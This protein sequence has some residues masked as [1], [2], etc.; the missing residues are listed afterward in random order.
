ME[1]KNSPQIVLYFHAGSENHGCEAIVRSTTDLLCE[2]PIL[3]SDNVS[4]DNAYGIE[5]VTDLRA[6]SKADFNIHEKIRI[7]LSGSDELAYHIRAGHE[8]KG[9]P[10][11]SIAFSIGGDNYCYGDTYNWHLSG[12]NEALHKRGIKTVLWGCSIEP[13][14]VTDKMKTDFSRYDL[15][16]AREHISYDYLKEL[17]PN[18]IFACDPAFTLKEERLPLPENFLEGKTVGINISPLIQK[19]E[20]EE[21][22]TYANYLN[23]INYILNDTD[24]HIALIPHVVQKGN[25]DREPLRKLY[26]EVEDKSRV[27]MIDDCNCM[28]LKGYISR[29][30]MFVGARTHATIAA[31]SSCVPTLVVGYSTKA[32]GIAQDLFGERDNH[33]LPV[34]KLNSINQMV[35]AF[36]DLDKEKE[37]IRSDLMSFIPGYSRT[38]VEA[39]EAV[40]ML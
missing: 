4:G 27:C 17:N 1:G 19:N 29:C 22:I 25:D 12:L 26:D 39:V 9:F 37:L 38:I 35:N 11:G 5:T 34:Q 24:Y 10:V 32:K 2:R 33:I 40:R 7:K 21:G 13:K 3:F 6:V 31:Y 30:A 16:V 18:T 14:S 28:Q 20:T 36:E 8:A 23:L 15:I